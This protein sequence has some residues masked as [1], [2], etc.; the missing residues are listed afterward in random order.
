M[1]ESIITQID[2]FLVE[3]SL[4][5]ILESRFGRYSKYVIQDR[6]LPDIRD[7]LKPVQ[8]RILYAMWKLN[9]KPTRVYKKSAR[10]VGDV[11]GKYHP[12]GDA[13]IYDAMIRLGQEW[14]TAYPLVDV[15]GNKGS[16]DDDPAAAMRYTEVRLTEAAMYSLENLSY[17][18]VPFILNFDDSEWEPTV[19][20][21]YFPNFLVNGAKG[22]SPGYATDVP[23]HNVGEVID[24]LKALIYNPNLE[25]AKLMTIIKGPDFPT[26]GT[27]YG[28]ENIYQMYTEGKGKLLIRATINVVTRNKKQ[29]LH[30]SDIPFEANKPLIIKKIEEAIVSKKISGLKQ[31]R[32]NSDKKGIAI[33][34]ELDTS[35]KNPNHIIQY[36]YKSTDLQRNYNA[37]L[38]AIAERRPK[39]LNLSSIL[40]LQLE[41][42]KD[43]TERKATFLLT[44]AT[45]RLE[46]IHGLIKAISILD[47]VIRTIRKSKDKSNAIF[48]LVKK[49]KFTENQATAIVNLRLHR[50]TSTDIYDLKNEQKEQQ[51]LINHYQKLLTNENY[52][53]KYLYSLLDEIKTKFAVK[54]KTKIEYNLPDT[55]FNLKEIMIEEEVGIIITRKGY[56]KC[57]SNYEENKNR[58]PL[59]KSGDALL[60]FELCSS[61]DTLVLLTSKGR[62]IIVPLYQL[63]KSKWTSHGEHVNSFTHI[64]G[65]EILISAIVIKSFAQVGKTKVITVTKNGMIK[66]TPLVE[67]ETTRIKKPV[68]CMR[69][70]KN[71]QMLAAALSTNDKDNFLLVTTKQKAMKIKV[72]EI[73]VTSLRAIGNKALK[74]TN[75]SLIYASIFNDDLTLFFDSSHYLNISINS[76][77]EKKRSNA[78]LKMHPKNIHAN[79]IG[80][81]QPAHTNFV[82]LLNADN[83]AIIL[84]TS[85]FKTKTK[86][87]LFKYE[88]EMPL[89][90][91]WFLVSSSLL[92]PKLFRT[93][94]NAA[95]AKN[96][97]KT[98]NNSINHELRKILN[99]KLKLRKVKKLTTKNKKEIAKME[100]AAKPKA[101]NKKKNVQT[102]TSIPKQ[103]PVVVTKKQIS[104]IASLPSTAKKKV[105]EIKKVIPKKTSAVISKTEKQPEATSDTLSNME[106]MFTRIT[107]K[108]KKEATFLKQTKKSAS[109]LETKT[110]KKVPASIAA[111]TKK[112]TDKHQSL[113]NKPSLKKIQT[114]KKL[115]SKSSEKQIKK[116]RITLPKKIKQPKTKTKTKIKPVSKLE[117]K[118]K[119]KVPTSIAATT[120]KTT[121]KHQSLPN[122]PS[123]KKVQ[124]TKKFT[125]KSPDKKKKAAVVTPP[126]K[127]KQPK[128]TTKPN[129]KKFNKK[130]IFED[131]ED[132][133]VID[134]KISDII[135]NDDE[136]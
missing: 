43:V 83:E 76:I 15:H 68:M 101:M 104:K 12:H 56:L 67:F 63:T 34:I 75:D 122:K 30:V 53:N 74:L 89:A 95:L 133:T 72:K 55:S 127:I 41:H 121:D 11:I 14:K 26:Y 109:K 57:F 84:P 88:K 44:K 117:T 24:A 98:M 61:K 36:L 35:V 31:V 99:K 5:T 126:K 21:A 38:L 33:D 48:N 80:I 87:K 39:V 106:I 1:K 108:V 49:F 86:N 64:D 6:A 115:Q 112:T 124:T 94:N 116:E 62:S 4:E 51:N 25:I 82:T 131:D 37:N 8:R 32:D 47:K 93:T 54:R 27:I 50:L 134:F 52:L 40:T 16:I 97:H 60:S 66:A 102:K 118:T 105:K 125:A 129:T 103:P 91:D 92:I 110:K 7:G 107:P 73:P 130:S 9:L 119:K 81:F 69:L 113:D 46:I 100:V 65:D 19:L 132:I 13:A 23:P 96:N 45:N 10:I 22:I 59:I 128:T 85:N 17:D 77:I 90:S 123:L 114:T 2:K 29:Y 70:Q 78:P 111:T 18:T 20:P 79:F 120:K 71:D 135:G 42:I 3:E 58:V 28:I 136:D